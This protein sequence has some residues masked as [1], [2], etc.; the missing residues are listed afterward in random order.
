[1]QGDLHRFIRPMKQK[2]AAVPKRS[3]LGLRKSNKEL[4][5]AGNYQTEEIK[6]MGSQLKVIYLIFCVSSK[7][8][9]LLH[10]IHFH[11]KYFLNY[12]CMYV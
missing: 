1:M 2:E 3:N 10:R 5:L 9:K 8:R 12:F 11:F 6:I 4:A 7:K